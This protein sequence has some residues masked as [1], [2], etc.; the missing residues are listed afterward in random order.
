MRRS[1][2]RAG[3]RRARDRRA[4]RATRSRRRCAASPRSRFGARR[5]A[6]PFPE[7]E[8]SRGRR[9]RRAASGAARPGTR[10]ASLLALSAG[11]A[12]TI[13]ATAPSSSAD[14]DLLASR[15]ASR[16]CGRGTSAARPGRSIL[17]GGGVDGVEAKRLRARPRR[18]ARDAALEQAQRCAP[19]VEPQLEIPGGLRPRRRPRGRASRAGRSG[20]RPGRARTGRR[21]GRPRARSRSAG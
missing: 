8:A 20:S 3:S 5:R 7:R 12:G 1:R 21:S 10:G 16:S 18:V 9:R 17:A 2:A 4:T 15:S 6:R 19:A 13:G 11:D 14:D